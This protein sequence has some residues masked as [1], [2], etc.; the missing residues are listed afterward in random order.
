M[1]GFSISLLVFWVVR[2]KSKLSM[3]KKYQISVTESSA[4]GLTNLSVFMAMVILHSIFIVALLNKNVSIEG[5]IITSQYFLSRI[6][7]RNL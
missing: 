4:N 1:V 7:R 2:S 6:M 5:I 3:I